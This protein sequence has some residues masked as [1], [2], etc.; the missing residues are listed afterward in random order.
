MCGVNHYSE[1]PAASACLLLTC[2]CGCERERMRGRRVWVVFVVSVFAAPTGSISCRNIKQ[3]CRRVWH[4]LPRHLHSISTGPLPHT[5]LSLA[6]SL[7]SPLELG[8]ILTTH[9]I[10]LIQ[11]FPHSPIRPHSST[12]ALE[13]THPASQALHA[14]PLLLP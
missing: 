2:G 4:K 6:L 13:N 11:A 1:A 8:N 10:T 14:A 5:H 9:A 3:V 7:Y 12:H